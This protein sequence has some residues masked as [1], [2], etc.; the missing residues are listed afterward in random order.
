M[1]WWMSKLFEWRFCHL[2]GLF[3]FVMGGFI[4]LT[5]KIWI[6]TAN[7]LTNRVFLL[8]QRLENDP[9]LS[10][11]HS[12]CAFWR[13]WRCTD[14]TIL[15]IP[16]IKLAVD[17]HLVSPSIKRSYRV[18]VWFKSTRTTRT[19]YLVTMRLST[20]ENYP[21]IYQTSLSGIPVD[22][23]NSLNPRGRFSISFFLRFRG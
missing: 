17:W 1:R 23:T 12:S 13:D 3:F 6:W 5:L 21:G 14:G 11:F 15:L 9:W 18:K 22:T 10:V 4:R 16:V 7:M 2:L 20:S 19:I 8:F